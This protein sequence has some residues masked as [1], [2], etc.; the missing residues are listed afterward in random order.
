[1]T[2]QEIDHRDL[3]SEII[4]HLLEKFK[5]LPVHNRNLI[6]LATIEATARVTAMET[7]YYSQKSNCSEDETNSRINEYVALYSSLVDVEVKKL[8][9]DYLFR[10]IKIRHVS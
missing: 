3:V 6:I 1:M 10:A 5:R 7:V 4:E 8:R 2:E 9:D